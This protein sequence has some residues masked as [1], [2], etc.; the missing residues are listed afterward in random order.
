MKTYKQFCEHYEYD[1]AS[2]ESRKL[3]AEYKK[4]L[5][6]FASIKEKKPAR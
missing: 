5:D 2:E 6:I 4:Q 1:E 3:Y